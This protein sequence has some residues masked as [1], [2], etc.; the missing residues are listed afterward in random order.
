MRRIIGSH[1]DELAVDAF[2]PGLDLVGDNVDAFE[3]VLEH[4]VVLVERADLVAHV[5]KLVLLLFGG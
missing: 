5:L 1:L 3:L 4:L 2:S